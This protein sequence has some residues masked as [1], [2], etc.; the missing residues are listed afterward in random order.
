M[1]T[2]Y[3]GCDHHVFMG[4]GVSMALKTKAKGGQVLVI[5]LGG[6]GLCTYLHNCFKEV[7]SYFLE[8]ISKKILC[9]LKT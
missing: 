4:V 7:K 6:G 5:G 9:F 1:D 3:L 8:I 2:G